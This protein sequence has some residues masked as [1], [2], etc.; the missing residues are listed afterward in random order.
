MTQKDPPKGAWR[1]M[2]DPKG[3][4]SRQGGFESQHGPNGA[5]LA[6]ARPVPQ[7]MC[8][9]PADNSA[10]VA[11]AF[12]AET[13]LLGGVAAPR[14][15]QPLAHARRRQ[16]RSSAALVSIALLLLL[17]AHTHRS[18]SSAQSPFGHT[19][20][21]TGGGGASPHPHS[22]SSSGGDT[23]DVGDAAAEAE[24]AA[25][26]VAAARAELGPNGAYSATKSVWG[27]TETLAASF[28]SDAE[29]YT[30]SGSGSVTADCEGDAY[31]YQ[32]EGSSGGVLA[33]TD[34]AV[35]PCASQVRLRSRTRAESVMKRRRA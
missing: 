19:R 24:A 13:P 2:V 20:G 5:V 26:A 16:F 32:S 22:S 33:L 14:G 7:P 27:R 12:S 11:T 6:H 25:E 21:G 31:S 23:G 18:F 30:L 35:A 15:A 9:S 10:E 1:T 3:F 17:A 34:G 4:E 29:T 8:C 28:D